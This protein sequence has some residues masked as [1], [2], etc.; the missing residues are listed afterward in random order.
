[1]RFDPNALTRIAAAALGALALAACAPQAHKTPGVIHL[2][3]ATPYPPNHPFSKADIAWMKE[4]EK[5]SGGRLKIDPFWGG[6]TI[7]SDQAVFELEH[8]VA[9]MALVMPIY[10]RAGA[11]TI[12]T[13]TAFY[14]GAD[15]P[16]QQIEVYHCLQQDYPVL[17]RE[18]PG[19]RIVAVQ[20]GSLSHIVT[21]NRTIRTLADLR[22]LRLRA[23]VEAAPV[24]RKLGA[25]P[26]I[27][28]MGEVYSALSKGTID[29]VVAPSDTLKSLHFSEVA[30]HIVN[31]KFARG[32]YP[33]R[34]ISNRAYAALP[35]DLQTLIDQSGSFWE[36]ALAADVTRSQEEGVVFGK[37]QGIEFTEPSAADQARVN[38]LEKEVAIEDAAK[39]EKIGVPGPQMFSRTQ[40]LI[41]RINAGQAA[42]PAS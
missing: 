28:P 6:T 32:G 17:A 29:G 16:A 22:G 9:D 20:G 31:L 27:M 41:G 34:A 33:A 3:Y 23:P 1:M 40:S 10:Q 4:I 2:R 12:K 35:A 7:S 37:A 13:Q 5:R 15:T 8:G 42:C 38:E 25:S 21:R 39:L 26:L 19:I 11:R 14:V 18:T 24:L 36:A 30:H